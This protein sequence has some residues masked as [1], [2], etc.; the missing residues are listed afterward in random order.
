[1]KGIRIDYFKNDIVNDSIKSTSHMSAYIIIY[2]YCLH[3]V[4]YTCVL[5]QQRF[6]FRVSIIIQVEPSI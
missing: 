2:V 5:V 4:Y 6:I 1:M 3:I